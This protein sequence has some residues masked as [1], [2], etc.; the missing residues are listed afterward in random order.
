MPATT[1]ANLKKRCSLSF[2]NRVPLPDE[3]RSN[4]ARLRHHICFCRLLTLL[5]HDCASLGSPGRHEPT[6]GYSHARSKT[7][8][9]RRL[10]AT[11][12]NSLNGGRGLGGTDL[13]PPASACSEP[14]LD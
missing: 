4:F 11:S 10:I 7:F 6:S 12:C 3:D 5:P 13:R 1:V 9:R 14:A 2:S 8:S